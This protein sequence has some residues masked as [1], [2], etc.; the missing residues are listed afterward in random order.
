MC[1]WCSM[2]HI[3]WQKLFDK[4]IQFTL[5]MISVFLAG[6]WET[7]IF[8]NHKTLCYVC[9]SEVSDS[10]LL[11]YYVQHRTHACMS[12]HTTQCVNKWMHAVSLWTP[13]ATPPPMYT[14]GQIIQLTFT[15]VKI[16][17]DHLVDFLKISFGILCDFYTYPRQSYNPSLCICRY[18][19]LGWGGEA[20][21]LHTLD[22]LRE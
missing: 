20:C 12:T 4:P 16:V 15:L 22:W 3:L 7:K 8:Y 10:R 13:G 19:E 11:F 21:A 1:T 17:W 2:D 6:S 5:E 14:L 18:G 9:G